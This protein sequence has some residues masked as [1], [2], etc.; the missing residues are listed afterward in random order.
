MLLFWG[1]GKSAQ[2][3]Q[4][5]DKCVFYIPYVFNEKDFDMDMNKIEKRKNFIINIVF[6]ALVLF[7]AFLFLEYAIKWIMPFLLGLV[8]TL[9]FRPLISLITRKTK[10]NKRFCAFVVVVAGYLLIGVL[11][12]KLGSACFSWVKEFCLNLPT[13]YTEDI[14]PFFST[15]NQGILDFA[16]RFS[17]E[18]AEQVGEILGSI[19]DN[20]QSYL[21]K[22]STNVLSYLAATSTRLPLWLISFVFTILS[23]LF[24]S[25]D[26]DHVME[27]VKRQIPE[28]N[29]LMIL[30]IKDYL[31]K[32]LAGYARAYLI[33]MLI[34]FV[35]LSVGLLALRVKNPFGIAAIIAVA[36]A[37]PVLGTGT[38][39]LPWAVISLFQQ[40]FYL[41]LGLFILY[42][43]VTAIRQFAEPKI[44]GDQL[45]LPP[46]VAIIC[47]YLGFV[48]FGVMGAILFPVTMNIVLSLQKAGKI[49]IWKNKGE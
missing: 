8:L 22:F 24:I 14:S 11:V 13:M 27:F 43:I 49:H 20:L 30:D 6:L 16:K 1:I 42:V 23:T 10:I 47:I 48:W 15:A 9:M 5:C 38:I 44:V 32:T 36:D 45:G 40:R 12:W 26:Y 19:L 2:N 39:V 28:K 41:A 25:M 18:T 31:G 3:V 37:L 29:K 21:L 17:P 46:I 33:L 4:D 34:T 35:E 7:L